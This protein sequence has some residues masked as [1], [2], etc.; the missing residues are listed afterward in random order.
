[1]LNFE[2]FGVEIL[3]SRQRK[4]HFP[5]L[6]F[7][8]VEIMNKLDTITHVAMSL[9]RAYLK[10]SEEKRNFFLLGCVCLLGCLVLSFGF[11]VDNPG[12]VIG[13]ILGSAIS[14]FCYLTIVWGAR[15]LLSGDEHQNK[16]GY[17]GAAFG[18]FR[19][20]FYAGGLVLGGFA[21]YV[22]GSSA[23]GYC[24]LWTVFAGYMPLFAILIITNL[25]SLR[26]KAPKKEEVAKQ[27]T[28]E[29]KKDVE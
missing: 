28:S 15:F 9:L 21:T 11:F 3:T 22:W 25:A 29:E 7:S 14:A 23:H 12:L 27:D 16:F 4:R 18:I 13:W 19:L 10:W 26:Q 24:N 6:L 8:W 1:M 17:L 20:A 5:P 2:Y